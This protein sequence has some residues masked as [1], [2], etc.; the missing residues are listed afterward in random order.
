[1][2]LYLKFRTL[3]PTIVRDEL[4]NLIELLT[5]AWNGLGALTDITYSA[6]GFTA[7]AGT[8]T[9]GSD[10]VTDLRYSRIGNRVNVWFNISGTTLSAG[11]TTCYVALPAALRARKQAFAPCQWMNNATQGAGYA[12]ID[13][14]GTMLNLAK[15]DFAAFAAAADTGFFGQLEYEVQQ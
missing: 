14:S 4:D 3:L 13:A 6:A 11:P 9:V 8:W 15:S 10:K 5:Q 7:S 12:W 1:M 2:N